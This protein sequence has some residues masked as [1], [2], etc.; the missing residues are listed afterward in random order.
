MPGMKTFP[1]APDLK[2]N[3]AGCSREKL[4]RLDT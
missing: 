4:A 2:M 3:M 1:G